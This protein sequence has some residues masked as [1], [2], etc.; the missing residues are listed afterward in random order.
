M[1]NEKLESYFMKEIAPILDE[2]EMSEELIKG[3][4]EN[5]NPS[6]MITV[7]FTKEEVNILVAMLD[8]ELPRLDSGSELFSPN[9]V[10]E[11]KLQLIKNKLTSK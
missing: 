10:R 7:S 9:L 6:D 4:E 3:M 5:N 8:L 2:I 1:E 11:A